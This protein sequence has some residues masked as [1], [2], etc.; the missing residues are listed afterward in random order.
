MVRAV[1]RPSESRR[2]EQFTGLW[3]DR[4]GN[5]WEC[6]RSFS[7]PTNTAFAWRSGM[8]FCALLR[9]S[10]HQFCRRSGHGFMAMPWRP[11]SVPLCSS[12]ATVTGEQMMPFE[13]YT[14]S[15]KRL[16]NVKR[17]MA[18]PFGMGGTL[19]SG[20]VAFY[21][22]PDFMD[23]PPEQVEPIMWVE[24]CPSQVWSLTFFPSTSST[25]LAEMKLTQKHGVCC[26]VVTFKVFYY[27]LSVCLLVVVVVVVVVIVVVVVVCMCCLH[28]CIVPSLLDLV[29]HIGACMYALKS[30]TYCFK[31]YSFTALTALP[32]RDKWGF[33]SWDKVSAARVAA[34]HYK[35]ICIAEA[36]GMLNFFFHSWRK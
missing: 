2:E 4:L 1:D 8:S 21:F 23:L 9:A 14:K 33:S 34:Q 30:N 18:I 16:K 11:A 35:K 24:R 12:A 20:M 29:M 17:V 26:C 32:H 19:M 36:V 31:N 3:Q 7:R 22:H 10:R 27:C 15:K 13:E 25:C 6:K 28:V 5:P